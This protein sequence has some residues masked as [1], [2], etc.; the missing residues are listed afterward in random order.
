MSG[1][2]KYSNFYVYVELVLWVL[3]GKVQKEPLLFFWRFIW[4]IYKPP[5]KT[6]GSLCSFQYQ[7]LKSSVE[8]F[9]LKYWWFWKNIHKTVWS[10]FSF[11]DFWILFT[12]LV[13]FKGYVIKSFNLVSCAYFKR[14]FIKSLKRRKETQKPK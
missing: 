3:K 14:K 11:L 1:A 8:L 12:Q 9:L 13:T 10:N 7:E 6:C 4:V 5:L 2:I